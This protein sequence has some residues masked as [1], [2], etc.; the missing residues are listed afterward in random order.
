M[1]VPKKFL[2]ESISKGWWLRPIDTEI[3]ISP[4]GAGRA[5]AKR[6]NKIVTDVSVFFRPSVATYQKRK[7]HRE[8]DVAQH[9][10]CSL[11]WPDFNVATSFLSR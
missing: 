8:K 4:K 11:S 6:P 10:S 3:S 2:G 5:V 9:P 1:Q 7:K